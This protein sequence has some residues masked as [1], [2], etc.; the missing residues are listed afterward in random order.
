MATEKCL[1][2]NP[3]LISNGFKRAGIYP[4]NPSEPDVNKLLP[5]SI[6]TPDQSV[7]SPPPSSFTL[8]V[9]QEA[10][11]SDFDD[12]GYHAHEVSINVADESIQNASTSHGID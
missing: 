12:P 11:T 5:S 7:P 8:S 9:P 3:A 1:R 4:W 10:A 2:S 6:F